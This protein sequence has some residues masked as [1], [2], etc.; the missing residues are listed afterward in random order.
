MRCISALPSLCCVSYCVVSICQSFI[1]LKAHLL[2]GHSLYRKCF[3]C[4]CVYP[5]AKT[6][7]ANMLT[8]K[9]PIWGQNKHVPCQFSYPTQKLKQLAHTK[10]S[11]GSCHSPGNLH[12]CSFAPPQLLGLAQPGLQIGRLNTESTNEGGS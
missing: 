6:V 8:C 9:H 2:I 4:I 12:E 5:T 3:W 7:I 10:H 1:Q 11:I